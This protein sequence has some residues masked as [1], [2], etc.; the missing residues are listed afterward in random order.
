MNRDES[1]GAK[2]ESDGESGDE[3]YEDEFNSGE[4][5]G[6]N[7]FVLNDVD[8]KSNSWQTIQ[9]TSDEQRGRIMKSST[10]KVGG[11]GGGVKT[12]LYALR[13]IT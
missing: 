1:C 9:F 11:G 13:G 5:E 4:D 10:D 8:E 2:D 7:D 3:D 6:D 12:T